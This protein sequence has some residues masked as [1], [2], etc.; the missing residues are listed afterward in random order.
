[1]EIGIIVGFILW[2]LTFVACC[3][4]YLIFRWA[5]TLDPWNLI[6]MFIGYVGGGAIFGVILTAVKGGA[7]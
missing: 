3:I 2:S 4:H 7:L 1:M 5:K 6:L